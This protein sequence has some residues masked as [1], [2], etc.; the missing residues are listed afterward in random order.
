MAR[1][2]SHVREWVTPRLVL[3]RRTRGAEDPCKRALQQIPSD[4]AVSPAFRD[5][6]FAPIGAGQLP[7]DRASRIRVVTEIDGR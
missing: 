6:R 2:C 5:L 1:G 3:G 4:D 7:A